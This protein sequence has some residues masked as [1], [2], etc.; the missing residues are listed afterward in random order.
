MMQYIALRRHAT[1]GADRGGRGSVAAMRTLVY[2]NHSLVTSDDVSHTLLQLTA[3]FATQ[4]VCEVVTIPT[5]ADASVVDVDVVVGLGT[6][7][8]STPLAWPQE[9][10]D[11]SAAVATLQLHPSYPRVAVTD[12]FEPQDDGLPWPVDDEFGSID[13][14]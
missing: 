14:F 7:L 10:P 4:S 6:H 12:P 5:V 13:R 9:D 1:L 11:F 3:G 2:G 8:I